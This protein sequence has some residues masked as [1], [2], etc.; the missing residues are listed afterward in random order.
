MNNI[1]IPQVCCMNA[2]FHITS[3]H[4]PSSMMVVPV[5]DFVSI[6]NFPPMQTTCILQTPVLTATL[7]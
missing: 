7:V 3:L 5:E 6:P 4:V 2:G 1:L